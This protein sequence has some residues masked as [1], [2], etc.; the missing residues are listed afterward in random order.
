VPSSISLKEISEVSNIRLTTIARMVRLLSLELGIL[1]PIADPTRCVTKVGNILGL[2][3]K[4]KR[5]AL[6]LMTH[7]KY[8]EYSGGKKPTSLAATVLYVTCSKTD[9]NI[10]LKEIAKAAGITEVTIRT[11]FRDL[12]AKNLI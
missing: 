10:S 7:I 5:Q 1:I 12:K 2:S 6:K 11:R 9:E 8:I 3:E 4:T